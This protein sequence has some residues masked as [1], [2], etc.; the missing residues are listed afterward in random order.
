V[1]VQLPNEDLE[2]KVAE[3]TL[4]VEQLLQNQSTLMPAPAVEAKVDE[5]EY[6]DTPFI[7]P[8]KMIQVTSLFNGGMTLTGLNNKKIRFENF[9]VTL[10][11]SF[12]DLTYISSHHRNLIEDGNIYINSKDVIKALYLEE[13]FRKVVNKSTIENIL[14]LS[15]DD[16]RRVYKNATKDIQDTIVEITLEGVKRHITQGDMKF[17]NRNKIEILSE[18]S[19]K[20]IYRIATEQLEEK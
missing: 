4:L 6:D 13:I 18:M 17:S 3:L 5:V 2:K 16:I 1:Q 20:N 9:G 10:P 14:E 7:Q 12:E 8:N 15:D 11:V 19:G